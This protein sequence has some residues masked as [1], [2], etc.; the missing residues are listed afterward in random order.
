[1]PV[2]VYKTKKPE[3]HNGCFFASVYCAAREDGVRYALRLGKSPRMVKCNDVYSSRIDAIKF[4]TE[5]Y[6]DKDAF[7]SELYDNYKKPCDVINKWYALVVPS[8]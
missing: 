6:A 3:L 8:F 4:S 7:L 1:M 2:C 5:T